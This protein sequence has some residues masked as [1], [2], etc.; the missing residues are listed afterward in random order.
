MP[1]PFD[2]MDSFKSLDPD[3]QKQIMDKFSS[4]SDEDKQTVMSK[5][6]TPMQLR[7][8]EGATPIAGPITTALT[9]GVGGASEGAASELPAIARVGKN[10]IETPAK[11]IEAARSIGEIALEGVKRIGGGIGEAANSIGNALK[12]TGEDAVAALTEKKASLPLEQAAK[13]NTLN[14]MQQ[15]AKNEIQTAEEKAGIGL[16]NVQ[17]NQNVLS[18]AFAARAAKISDLGADRLAASMD[19]RTLQLMRKTTSLGFKQGGAEAP[20]YAKAN[21]VFTE[22]LSK[23][24]PEVGTALS[25]Y[26]D[27]QKVINDLPD[28]FANQKQM[29]NLALAKAKNLAKSQAVV[30]QAVKYAGG[31]TAAAL[32]YNAVKKSLGE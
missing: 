32:G 31:G 11:T 24:Q 12:G 30:K 18:P 7:A 26:N 15:A 9:L 3:T 25:K 28:Q 29:L 16:T 17:P 13:S 2:H 14:I 21:K 23:Q 4:L 10:I 19:S 27:I 8:S 6:N 5:A 20:L 1:T 22:A